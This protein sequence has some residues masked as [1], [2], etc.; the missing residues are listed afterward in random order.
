M[1]EELEIKGLWW[2]PEKP[3]LKLPGTLTFSPYKGFSLEV[4]GSFKE[5]GE[6]R[7]AQIFNTRYNFRIFSSRERNYFI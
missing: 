1:I 2:L 3:D 5:R 4:Q 6:M 7:N